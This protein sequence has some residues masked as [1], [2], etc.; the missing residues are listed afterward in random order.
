MPRVSLPGGAG[1]AAEAGREARVAQRQVVLGQDLVGVQGG[2]ADLGGADQVQVVAARSRRSEPGRSAGSR[3]RT[4]APRAPARA[5]RPGTKP[6]PGELLERELD[7]RQL[8]PA[9]GRPS[10]RRTASRTRGPR[11]P[12]RSGPARVPS[13][14]WSRGSKP[15]SRRLAHLAHHL[16]VLLAVAVGGGRVGQ[17]RERRA[18]ARSICSL[19]LRQLLL[20]RLDL[21]ASARA[22]PRS[23]SSA[24]APSRLARGDL[25]GDAVLL[26]RG[27]PRPAGSSSRRRRRAPAARRPPPPAPRRASAALTPSGSLPDQ[28]EVERGRPTS[29]RSSAPAAPVARRRPPSAGP[30]GSRPCCRRTS[31]TNSATASASSPTTMFCG[32]IAP[33]EAAVADRV[34]DLVLGLPALVEVRAG[35]ALARDCCPRVPA[36]SRVW[37]PRSARRRAAA[38]RLST[39]TPSL[40]QPAGHER[41]AP[42]ARAAKCQ[43]GGAGSRGGIIITRAGVSDGAGRE[44]RAAANPVSRPAPVGQRGSRAVRL[45]RARRLRLSGG[46][47]RT[48]RRRMGRRRTA[49]HL[50]D[51]PDGRFA[52]PWP[53]P[54]VDPAAFRDVCGRFATGVCVV[55]ELRAGRAVRA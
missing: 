54:A 32:M 16:R 44:R 30:A 17:V 39:S 29:A 8:E 24:S 9:P 38:P 2:E 7:Q 19:D 31:A 15:N 46:S 20:E 14:R 6:V 18:A 33:G 37:Q 11:S 55:T 27:A 43:G 3:S 4:A 34:Q 49:F 22:S 36:A 12:C 21:R 41:R 28:L 45:P 47:A 51:A 50:A 10:G 48:E 23:R 25:L 42:R 53:R 26:A 35:G 5:G 1:L 40:P 52:R 13:S